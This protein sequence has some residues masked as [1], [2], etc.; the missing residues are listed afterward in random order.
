[1]VEEAQIV[2]HKSHHPDFLIDLPHADCL[3][4]ERLT[5]IDLP[6]SDADATAAGDDDGAVME[7]ILN[8]E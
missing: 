1:M 6:L 7:G 3:F 2:I 4:C 5:E 8:L